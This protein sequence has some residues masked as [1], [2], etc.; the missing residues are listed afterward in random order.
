MPG[1]RQWDGEGDPPILVVGPMSRFDA[2]RFTALGLDAGF[3]TYF[4]LDA[5]VVT[6][7]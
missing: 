4:S 2:K 1:S 3:L 5:N 7:K 6:Y